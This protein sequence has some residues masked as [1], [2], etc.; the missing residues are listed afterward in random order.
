[1]AVTGRAG[2]AGKTFNFLATSNRPAPAV[3][4][5]VVPVVASTTLDANLKGTFTINLAGASTTTPAVITIVQASASLTP[6]NLGTVGLQATV[7]DPAVVG[8]SILPTPSGGITAKLGTTTSVAVAVTDQF[9]APSVGAVVR[10]Y[11]T[12]STGTLLSTGTT[13]ATGVATVSV[14]GSTGITSGTTETY[15]FTAQPIGVVTPVLA[16][17]NLQVTYTTSGDVTAVTVGLVSNTGATSPIS[18]TTTGVTLIPLIATPFNGA[19]DTNGGNTSVWNL[20]TGAVV[21][22]GALAGNRVQFT[23]AP[24][25]ANTVT[26]TTPEGVFVSDSGTTAAKLAWNV[27]TR[28]VT[29]PSGGNV[30]VFATKTGTH[31]VS[32]TSGA[33]TTKV[34]IQVVAPPESAYNI[35][36]TPATQELKAGAFGTATLTVTDV[37][38][39]KVPNT[40]VGP[41]PTGGVAMSASGEVL[42]AGLNANLP[43]VT[44]VDGTATITL[45]AGRTGEGTVSAAPL[46]AATNL[47]LAWR[48]G[49]V[50]PTGA[51]APVTSASIKVTIAPEV[52]KSITITGSRTT[53]SGKPGIKVDGAVT[54][55]ENGKTVIP[56]F[57]FPGETTFAQGSARPVISGGKFTWERKTGKK[58]YA[59]VTSDDGKTT[60]NRVVIAAN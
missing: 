26:V 34:K 27:G 30:W 58:F 60:S 7:A 23:A 49:Y 54:G 14:S 5:T 57:R 35:G 24:T 45:I 25:P 4:N 12:S 41:P 18:N 50:P 37:F 28:S 43:A 40:L 17:A 19:A 11:R 3:P 16:T 48:A 56:Y 59:Y 21:T 13:N 20:A 33:V 22:G 47:A 52:T 6:V 44:G 2:Q 32:F 8:A 38:G 51:P 29:I 55:I 39:N 36:L 9:G 31:E 10:A 53:V 15:V 1:M 46:T 42:L